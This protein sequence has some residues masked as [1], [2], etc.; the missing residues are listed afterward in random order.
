VG[1]ACATLR[2]FG[3]RRG[4]E[5]EAIAVTAGATAVESSPAVDA[6]L[7]EI[8]K[9]LVKEAVSDCPDAGSSLDEA[10]AKPRPQRS[11]RGRTRLHGYVLDEI[12]YQLEAI[13]VPG[14]LDAMPEHTWAEL[15]VDSLDLVELVKALED[16]FDVTISDEDLKPI[17][18]VGA[19]IE[20]VVTLVEETG[21]S[22]SSRSCRGDCVWYAGCPAAPSRSTNGGTGRSHV[23]RS[24]PR[25]LV[26]SSE[27][28]QR[29]PAA[30]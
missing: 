8:L 22:S 4:A 16:R 28:P 20:M 27:G 5:A 2:G 25:R 7:A 11:G 10:T 23:P 3:D 24:R 18:T 12:R 26:A 17:D 19:A 6:A 21:R 30:P 9:D 14:A 1:D 13:K 29:R 15:A